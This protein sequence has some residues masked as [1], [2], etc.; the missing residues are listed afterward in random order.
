MIN[1]YPL[2]QIGKTTGWSRDACRLAWHGRQSLEPSD[3]RMVHTN[4]RY[5]VYK[6]Y[7]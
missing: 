7:N 5:S 1:R 6:H 4:S 2:M 3:V